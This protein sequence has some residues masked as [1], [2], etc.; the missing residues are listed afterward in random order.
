MIFQNSFHASKTS[1]I[2]IRWTCF[3]K[4]IEMQIDTV[5]GLTILINVLFE[6][7]TLEEAYAV[8]FAKVCK[9]LS[10]LKVQINNEDE[11]SSAD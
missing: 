5:K 9:Q 4:L 7:A 6:K 3:Q 10:F 11:D 8:T 1:I 2:D